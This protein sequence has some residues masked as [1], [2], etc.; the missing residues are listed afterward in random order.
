MFTHWPP[1][2]H[3][4]EPEDEEGRLKGERSEGRL[5]CGLRLTD[6][7]LVAVDVAGAANVSRRA[8]TVEVAGDG[9]GVTLRAVSAWVTH[10]GIF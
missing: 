8:V 10:A 4:L 7:A 1:C 3:G 5:F 6:A 2:S 9:V